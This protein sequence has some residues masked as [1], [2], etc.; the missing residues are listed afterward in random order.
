MLR[1]WWAVAVIVLVPVLSEAQSASDTASYHKAQT[2]VNDGNAAAGRAIVDSMIA[3]ATPGTNEYA[4]GLYWRAVLSA[5]AAD[6]EM[7]YRRII[8]DYTL[9]PRVGDVLLRLAQLELARADYDGALQ[10]L[11]RLTLEHPGGPGR[12]RAGY[13]TARVLFEK[14]DIQRAC[15]VNAD[16]LARTSEQDTE[17]RNQIA[18]LNQRCADVVVAAVPVDSSVRD[19][20]KTTAKP[21]SAAS[22][23][24]QVSAPVGATEVVK[25]AVVAVK[26]SMPAPTTPRDAKPSMIEPPAR[27]NVSTEI[28]AGVSAG[29]GQYSVQI[30][31]YNV[32]SQA[33]A[34]VAK[35]KKKGYEARVS[36]SS[37]PFRVRIGR[38]A[39]QA[40]ATA[41]MR[42]LKAKLIDGFVVKA[43]PR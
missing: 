23:P 4:E 13:W 27:E 30:A 18:Y 14:N 29:E 15:A 1:K 2:L 32:K 8:V 37:A 28:S 40:Q 24:A 17:L 42:S 35:L 43:E 3:R 34:M 12:A 19:S 6:A 20:T 25:T 39:T 22:I 10:H 9:S 7:D 31:A 5:T 38:Y 11:N 21:N 33:N 41:V 26:P 36:G 16:A